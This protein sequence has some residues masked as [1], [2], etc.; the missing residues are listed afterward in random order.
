MKITGPLVIDLSLWND[1]INVQ[2]LINSGV[3][4]VIMG[5]YRAPNSDKLNTNCQRILDQLK[6]SP[7]ILQA[8]YYYYP[9]YNWD[10]E[11]DWY[12]NT[13]ATSGAKFCF[14]WADCEDYS[15]TMD[16]NTRSE[17]YR[18]FTDH[19]AESLPQMG[20]YTSKSFIDAHAPGMNTWISKY[21]AWVPEYLY[22]PKYTVT[23]DWG[24]FKRQ[25]LPA[26]TSYDVTQSPAQNSMVG[27]QC[28]GDIFRLPGAY[29]A[30]N[31]QQP[32]DIS[33]FTQEFI[34]EISCGTPI[35]PLPDPEPDPEP[36]PPGPEPLP[37]YPAYKTTNAVNVRQQNNSTSTLLGTMP[38]NTI[39]YIDI[40]NPGQY[41]HFRPNTQFKSGGWIATQY[42][43]ATTPP[44]IYPAYVVKAY[45]PYIHALPS[46]SSPS[47]GYITAGTIVHVDTI[48]TTN[49][50]SHIQPLL[51]SFI[52]GGWVA[53]SFLQKA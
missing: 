40:Y 52:N 34:N 15:A 16:V 18:L 51:P 29:T 17:M 8:Y 2:E 48:D 21:R 30:Y 37:P 6:D 45:N 24:T 50:Y 41:S 10:S 53:T 11:A 9:Q 49:G 5:L 39:V 38:A 1:H 19:V 20:V 36:T 33:V 14:A 32:L 12:L 26:L 13:I 42:L 44:S 47:L 3:V 28:T 7:F 35:S 4:S 46:A 25:Y 23:T 22:Q 31:Q 43:Q 27:H